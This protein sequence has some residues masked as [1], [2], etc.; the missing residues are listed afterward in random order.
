MSQARLYVFA[1]MRQL[2]G[3]LLMSFYAKIVS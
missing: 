3:V 1:R 2:F